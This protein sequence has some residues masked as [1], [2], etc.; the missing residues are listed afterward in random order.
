MIEQVISEIIAAEETAEKIRQDAEKQA[1]DITAEAEKRATD[2]KNATAARVKARKIKRNAEAVKKADSA[3]A[4]ITQAATQRA[5]ELLNSGDD[6][7]KKAGD[8]IYRRI[9]NGDC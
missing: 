5:E 3:F 2:T 8:E 1:A 7:V 4:E 9:I 6:A